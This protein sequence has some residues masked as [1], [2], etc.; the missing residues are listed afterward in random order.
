MDVKGPVKEATS[1]GKRTIDNAADHAQDTANTATKGVAAVTD[2]VQR[3]I[4]QSLADQPYITL[5]MAAAAGFVI[6]AI[7]KS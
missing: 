1:T 5:F 3:A 2:N 7:W 6:G 4:D